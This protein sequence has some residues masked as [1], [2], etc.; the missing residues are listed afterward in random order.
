MTL[1]SALH[2]KRRVAIVCVSIAS[3]LAAT[4]GGLAAAGA[5]NH[6]ASGMNPGEPLPKQATPAAEAMA[7]AF[8]SPS[9]VAAIPS[10]VNDEVTALVAGAPPQDA[11]GKVLLDQGRVLLSNL[12]PNGRT[13]YAY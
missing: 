3:A 10:S 1:H 13:I 6:R 11:L 12:G 4:G 2:T 5:F 7:K 9:S 8:A